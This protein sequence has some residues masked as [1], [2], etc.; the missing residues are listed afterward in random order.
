MSNPLLS[1]VWADDGIVSWL[2]VGRQKLLLRR[3]QPDECG[4]E[5]VFTHSAVV[6]PGGLVLRTAS[7]SLCPS[8]HGPSSRL[9]CS[10]WHI[11]GPSSRWLSPGCVGWGYCSNGW[12]DLGRTAT[13]PMLAEWSRPVATASMNAVIPPCWLSSRRDQYA[14]QV[15]RVS[16]SVGLLNRFFAL[17]CKLN[18][19]N[20]V[21]LKLACDTLASFQPSFV[22]LKSIRFGQSE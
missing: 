18:S 19:V 12:A 11:I 17:L 9:R 6:R 2:K 7:P 16:Q 4:Y 22:Y 21:P 5:S 3:R 10:A 14:A 20:E 1:S 13:P 8:P 15:H